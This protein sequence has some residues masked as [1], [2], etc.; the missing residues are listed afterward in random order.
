MLVVL[1]R[2]CPRRQNRTIGR[3]Q[4]RASS[5]IEAATYSCMLGI[6]ERDDHFEGVTTYDDLYNA[7]WRYLNDRC[8]ADTCPPPADHEGSTFPIPRTTNADAR[9]LAR[10]WRGVV[11]AADAVPSHEFLRTVDDVE[12]L[13]AGATPSDLYAQNNELWRALKRV[14][15]RR[16]IVGLARAA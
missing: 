4:S 14:A 15:T 1:G 9:G 3:R 6:I 5:G 16:Q 13:T 7:Q 10:Y 8:G 2:I 11:A 12:R